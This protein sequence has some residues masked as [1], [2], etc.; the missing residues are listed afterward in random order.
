MTGPKRAHL[1][2]VLLLAGSSA[3]RHIT[4]SMVGMFETFFPAWL[5]GAGNPNWGTLV[6]NSEGEITLTLSGIVS[7]KALGFRMRGRLTLEVLVS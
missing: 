3:F 6:I 2:A 4:H 5:G 1:H 7:V